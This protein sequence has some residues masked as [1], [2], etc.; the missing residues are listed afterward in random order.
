MN[1]ENALPQTS[2][3]YSIFAFQAL[4]TPPPPEFQKQ[5]PASRSRPAS[6]SHQPST[7]RSSLAPSASHPSVSDTPKPR[8]DLEASIS[9]ITHAEFDKTPG[10]MKGRLKFEEV[11]DFITI[12]NTTLNLKTSYLKNPRAALVSKKQDLVARWKAD[13]N[14]ELANQYHLTAEDFQQL[15]NVKL[16]KK[17]LQIMQILR[18][19]KRIK[20]TRYF[21]TVY[22]IALL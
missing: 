13:K 14:P 17:E 18:H 11:N 6:V 19:F 10:Y 4:A 3:F 21:K 8:R 1:F 20:E 5:E 2:L 9:Y 22:F 7:P 15:S 16:F 12:Y